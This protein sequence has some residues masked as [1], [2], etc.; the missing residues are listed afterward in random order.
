MKLWGT[1]DKPR[2]EECQKL[3]S[4]LNPGTEHLAAPNVE[5]RDID[6]G[7]YG[8]SNARLGALMRS[9]RPCPCGNPVCR[10][11]SPEVQILSGKALRR[12]DKVTAAAAVY[13]LP[14]RMPRY[15]RCLLT[16]IVS[17]LIAKVQ[18]IPGRGCSKLR[19]HR[20]TVQPGR[21]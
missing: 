8:C 9:I 6:L 12:L 16:F 18:Y 15:L 21:N 1:G 11:R 7:D 20:C 2:C 17:L 13:P 4:S 10:L 19:P 5:M 3:D 14:S